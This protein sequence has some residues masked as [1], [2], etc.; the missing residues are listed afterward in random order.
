MCAK[1]AKIFEI[2]GDQWLDGGAEGMKNFLMGGQVSMA[3]LKTTKSLKLYVLLDNSGGVKIV[4]RTSVL[5][6][7]AVNLF[8]S[9]NFM[10]LCAKKPE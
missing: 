4:T 10:S 6:A 7:N 3:Y 5:W 1:R 8:K 9:C 2:L